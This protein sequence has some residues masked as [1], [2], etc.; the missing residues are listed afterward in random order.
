MKQ[1]FLAPGR[2][3]SLRRRH[4]WVFSGA[5]A[6]VDGAPQRGDSVVVRSS[7]GVFLGHG[8]YCPK[9]QIRVRVMSFDEA[10]PIDAAL[11][12][13]RIDAALAFRARALPADVTAL[14]LVHGEADGLP[15]LVVDRYDDVL[16]VQCQSAAAEH[17]RD[18]A[19]AA[20]E[21][22]RWRAVV[23]RSDVEVR[24]L[25]GL[26]P[27]SGVLHGTL[28]AAPL[29]IDEGGVRYHVDVLH[30][31]K[32]GFFLDQRD[33]RALVGA[34][35]AGG[36]VLDVFC[37]SGGF[38]L[39]A[40]AGGAAHVTAV[41]SSTDALAQARAN[42][43]LNGC[44]DG[45]VRVAWQAEDAFAALRALHAAGRRF[46]LVVLDPPK[47]APTGRHVQ[48]AARAYKDVNLWALK[49]LRAG[50]RLFTFSCSGAVDDA[51]FQS[52]VAGAAVDAG[53]EAR[54]LARLAAAAD[55]PLALNFP[56]GAYLTGL[57]V[58]VG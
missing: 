43:A 6:R 22:A 15:G 24:A 14:R 38:T 28:P 26:A 48:R 11:V 53:V 31:Q 52:I 34:A 13:R 50:G 49:L 39:A 40:L 37:Y 42:A 41:D 10:V 25:E 3:K 4:P 57:A 19:V 30:G 23:E 51:L 8:V 54:V 12:T 2:D 36:E 7:A 27:R 21:P 33:N 58:M 55:H 9:S 56:E 1:V 5:V 18:A 35:A 32:T 45:D 44:D 29:V 16:V 17:W 46:D 20:L 47:F